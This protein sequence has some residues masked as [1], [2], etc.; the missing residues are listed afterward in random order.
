MKKLVL[1]ALIFLIPLAV[2]SINL[3]PAMRCKGYGAYCLQ[4][5]IAFFK[6]K[7]D[8]TQT[9]E[10]KWN[11]KISPANEFLKKL[12]SRLKVKQITA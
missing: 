6:H 8:N 10:A 7:F 2:V 4:S 5:A 3:A 12:V 11:Q 1:S 9:I